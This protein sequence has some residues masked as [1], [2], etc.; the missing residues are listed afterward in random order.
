MKLLIHK[1]GIE[2]YRFIQTSLV[3][4]LHIQGYFGW[5]INFM[6]LNFL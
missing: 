1:C 6:I 2:Y 4:V 3:K 5:I